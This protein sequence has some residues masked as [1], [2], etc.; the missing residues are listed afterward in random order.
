[1]T[2]R[3]LSPLLLLLV[4]CAPVVAG[5]TRGSS[6][7]PP[8][9]PETGY[10]GFQPPEVGDV[11]V[12]DTLLNQDTTGGVSQQLAGIAGSPG[13][14]FGLVWRDQRDGML[15]YYFARLD[16]D[17][18]LREPERPV[19]SVPGTTRRFDPAVAIAAD[20]SGGVSWISRHPTG[21]R[22]WLRCFNAEGAWFGTDLIIA[23]GEGPAQGRG[24]AAREGGGPG[25]RFP[26][27]LARR[28]GSRTL[29]WNEGGRLRTADFDI[30][31]GPLRA[32]ADLGPAGTEPEAGILGLEDGE[33]GVAALWTG[34]G[35]VW[36]AHRAATG[37]RTTDAQLGEG[38]ARGLVADPSGG[39]WVLVQRG[40]VAVLRHVS[41]DGKPTGPEFTHNLPGL[42]DLELT[43]FSGGLALLAT[44]GD[45][46]PAAGRE[47]GRGKPAREQMAGPSSREPAAQRPAARGGAQRGEAQ[48]KDATPARLEL[49]FH[50]LAGAP[51][52]PEPLVVTSAAARDVGDAHIASN[53]A[54]L[55]V[56]WTDTRAG[57]GDVWGRIV[58]PALAGPARLGAEK[59]LNSD[60]AS[61]DQINPDLDVAGDR[62]WTVWQ[63]RRSGTGVV[64]AR[65]FGAAGPIGNEILLP[66]GQAGAPAPQVLGGAVDPTVALRPDGSWLATWVQREEG[67]SRVLG[68]VLDRDGAPKSALIE[69]DAREPATTERAAVSRLDGDRGWIVVWPAG[70]KLGIFGRRVAPDG[71]CAGPARRVNDAGD[72]ETM[73]ADVTLLDD[74]RLVAGWTVHTAGAPREKGWS[75]RAR[76]LDADGVPKGA[77]IAFEAS[78]RLEDH[79]PALAPAKNGGFLMAWCSG[80]PSDPT[81][82]VNVRLFDAQGRPAGPN[83]TPCY[84]ANEQDFADIARLA[85]GSFAVA[86]EDDISYFDQGY[87][88]RIGADGKSMGPWMR[89]GKLDTRFIP[90]RVE[91]RIAAFGDGWAAVFADRQRSQGFDVRIKI[92]GPRFDPPSGG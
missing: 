2:Q 56:A 23:A 52:D 70:G 72:D 32:A 1:M 66:V 60:V 74:G 5:T 33:S 42:R 26:V 44:R 88:R 79:D 87:V 83:L 38:R 43:G 50:D 46:P 34:K 13:S 12:S 3:R 62:G 21:Q 69:I 59:R 29:L 37:S 80:I 27:L 22:P 16:A 6:E 17:A 7:D 14:G 86:W 35:G 41:P 40:E 39:F 8:H 47:S 65:A 67:R 84:L 68:Q 45:A 63:D 25:A 10:L 92:V 78:R 55:L 53:G 11:R 24:G 57:D 58:D 9:D 36:F 15:G 81:H 89:I 91:P 18:N 30:A 49:W 51:T 75:V 73:H 64:Y 71:T 20:G 82:D 31:G 85:D 90:D 61:T 28:D 54:R 77:E 19:T 76:F 48:P 4:A